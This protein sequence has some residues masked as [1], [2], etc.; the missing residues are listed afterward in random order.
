MVGDLRKE[1]G[2]AIS[3]ICKMGG[4]R[5]IK[6]ATLPDCVHMYVSIPPK[7]SVEKIVG[8]IKGISLQKFHL[9]NFTR[10]VM[11]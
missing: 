5:I 2:E 10:Y 9:P 7:E 8:R 6:A 3:K 11:L 1:V 4:V